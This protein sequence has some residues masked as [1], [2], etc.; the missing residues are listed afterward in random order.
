MRLDMHND[1]LIEELDGL[2]VRIPAAAPAACEAMSNVVRPALI[3]A[4]PY[5]GSPAH[6]DKHLKDIIV[7]TRRKR[8]TSDSE[9]RII[10]ISPR[11]IKGSVKGP[12]AKKNWD[13][14]K[15]IYK[16]VVSE[17]GRSN[18]AARPFWGITVVR[19]SDE[20]LAAGV[21]VL[22]EAAEK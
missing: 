7:S 2:A 16:L 12:K 9:E 22:K 21:K 4:A 19:K 20:A 1:A 17:F 8:K 10:W 15:H 6:K 13:A 18:M 11:G 14:D 5:D 3:A